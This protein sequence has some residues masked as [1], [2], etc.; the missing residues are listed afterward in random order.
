[1]SRT[2]MAWL[3]GSF[4]GKLVNPER[5]LRIKEKFFL[6]GNQSVKATPMGGNMFRLSTDEGVKLEDVFKDEGF[7]L[8]Q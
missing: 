5:F 3:K 7:S 6:K 8:S 1:M 2:N 4:V